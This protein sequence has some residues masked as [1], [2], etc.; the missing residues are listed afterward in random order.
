MIQC[1]VLR[2]FL[3]TFHA[4]SWSIGRDERWLGWEHSRVSS[5]Y[6]RMRQPMRNCT[7]REQEVWGETLG[8][9]EPH[10]LG[11]GSLHPHATALL[12]HA[13]RANLVG[14]AKGLGRG[15]AEGKVFDFGTED[16]QE[17]QRPDQ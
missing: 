5:S 2:T 8:V 1:A 12:L 9:A 10:A 3:R 7:Q 4:H 14:A 17:H 13:G 15:V 16:M 6:S 11:S